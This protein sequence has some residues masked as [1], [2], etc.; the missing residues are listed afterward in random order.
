MNYACI[1][2]MIILFHQLPNMANSSHKPTFF[3]GIIKLFLLNLADVWANRLRFLKKKQKFFQLEILLPQTIKEK[4]IYF[5]TKKIFK[6]FELHHHWHRRRK[7][8][9]VIYNF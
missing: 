7:C 8:F 4:E 2:T 3:L 6:N 9:R 5:S 1:R